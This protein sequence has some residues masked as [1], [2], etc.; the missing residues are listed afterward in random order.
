MTTT[1]YPV[2]KLKMPA[3]LAGIK[4]GEISPKPFPSWV[5]NEVTADWE[6]L[7]PPPKGMYYWDEENQNWIKSNLENN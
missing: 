4:N 3:D 1:T 2:L 7:V 5:F 6:S